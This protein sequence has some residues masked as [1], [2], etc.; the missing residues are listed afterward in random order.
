MRLHLLLP[1]LFLD[2]T[3]MLGACGDLSNDDLSFIAA[4][5]RA[6]E[7]ELHVG[8]DTADASSAMTASPGVVGDPSEFFTNAGTT[9]GGVNNSV[10]GVLSLLD[11]LGRGHKPT[12]RQSGRRV[13]GPARNFGG[14][15]ITLVLDVHRDTRANGNPHF[16]FCLFAGRDADFT[17]PMPSCAD[18]ARG[19]LVLV[20]WAEHAPLDAVG[21]VRS[22]EGQLRIDRDALIAGGYSGLESGKL[23]MQFDFSHGGTDKQLHLDV[24]TP[25]TVFFP[26]RQISY[27]YGKSGDAI[28]FHFQFDA[29]LVGGLAH[30][31]LET[32]VLD[33]VWTEGGLGRADGTIEGGDLP[34]DA[35][36][37]AT[38]CW[39]A[40]HRR[41]YY[42]L[43]V[44]LHPELNEL[45]GDIG[46]CPP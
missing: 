15:G 38:E 41:T 11:A 32:A 35:T 42:R 37:T 43:D 19:G 45:E 1:L 22:G 39:N 24:T 21:A 10:S 44:P 40:R 2:A 27:E 20:L 31:A 12:T 36:V 9:A 18:T 46:S 25:A 4:A 33:A 30:R 14:L 13:W 3:A 29:N 5:P 26:E 23:G 7:L 8:S 17:G 28:D 16:V 34:A 6:N